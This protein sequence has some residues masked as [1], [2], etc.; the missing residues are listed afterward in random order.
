MEWPPYSP[1]MNSIEHLWFQLKEVVY[2][3]NPDIEWVGDNDEI[4]PEILFEEFFKAWED[5]DQYYLHELVRSMEKRVKVL[6]AAK[7]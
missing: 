5:I 3:I 1:D 2:K 4:V 7:G 6:I